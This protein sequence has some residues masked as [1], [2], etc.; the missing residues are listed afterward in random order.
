[1][2]DS[3]ITV[4]ALNGTLKPSPAPSSTELIGSQLLAEFASLG[5][6]GDSVRLVDFTISP[7][8]EADMGGSDEWPELR[9]RVLA[10]DIVAFCTPTWL[11]Q[12]SSVMHRV[13]ER[14]DAELSATDDEGRPILFD[15]VAVTAVVGNEDGAHK[16][17]ADLY[18]ALSDVGFTIPAQGG[19]YWNG[20]AMHT[21][22]YKDLDKTP[23][24]VRSAN[25]TVARNA[26]HLARLLAQGPYPAGA[27]D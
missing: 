24:A 13:L 20:Q 22:D 11:G 8:V 23:D 16:I 7:G 9:K 1:M 18:Q 25:A 12:M 15:K 14:L 21:V 19:T 2:N 3:Q 6:T 26:V 10:A 17:T 27:S 4:L 5:V